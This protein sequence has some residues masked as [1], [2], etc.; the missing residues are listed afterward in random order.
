M[1]GNPMKERDTS[2]S[3][4]LYRKARKIIPGGTQLLSKRPEIFAP[5]VWPAYYSKANGC[6]VWDL[7]G[8]HYYDMSIN[9]VGACLLGYHDPDV[10]AA[11]K[12]A[13]DNGVMC[14][15]NPPEEVEL[16]EKLCQIHPWAENVRFARCGG[17]AMAVAVRIARATTGKSKV[18][19]CGYHGWH[20]WYIAANLGE[21][22]SL[23]GLLLP[24]LLPSGVPVELRNTTLPFQGGDIHAFREILTKHQG[25]L[26]AVVMEPCRSTFYPPEFLA[27][28]RET[29][30]K[31]KIILI[32]DEITIG[33]RLCYG[34]AHLKIGIQPDM[35][36]FA[37][38]LGNGHPMAAIIGTAKAMAGTQESFISSTYWTERTGPA[39]ALATLKKMERI[40]VPAQVEKTGQAVKALW[41][42]YGQ[43]Y[44][45]PIEVDDAFPAL[46]HFAFQH[47]KA[48]VLKTLFIQKM[49]K[50][51]FLAGL[52]FSPTIA[53]QQNVLD[54]YGKALDSVFSTLAKSLQSEN[55][56]QFLCGPEAHQGFK[57]L[58][59]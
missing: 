5:E 32:F 22:N 11:V 12:N 29:T 26:A 1:T 43:K 7:D 37:K 25:E 36:A 52:V 53:H 44:A 33:W 20:D 28:I 58:A 45:L 40:N 54:Q 56:E 59:N 48:N 27:E 15:L 34:G 30:E 38:S 4:N 17:E 24:G 16:A 31:N 9:G 19:V 3:L 50:E 8:N 23:Q 47:E 10:T 21:A 18:A 57:R 13:I 49:L 42:R 2:T 39:A 51:G 35:A 6:E 41:R 14:T 55:L 46:A